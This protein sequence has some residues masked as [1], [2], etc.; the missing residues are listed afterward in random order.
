MNAYEFGLK[1]FNMRY[2]PLPNC[3][4][5]NDKT[6]IIDVENSSTGENYITP[7]Y[8]Y[9]EV[10][11]QTMQFV[12]YDY[13]LIRSRIPKRLN[14]DVVEDYLIPNGYIEPSYN[15]RIDGLPIEDTFTVYQYGQEYYIKVLINQNLEDEDPYEPNEF[16]DSFEIKAPRA[17]TPKFFGSSEVKLRE[18]V[19]NESISVVFFFS[20]DGALLE[21]IYAQLKKVEAN[22]IVF[23]LEKPLLHRALSVTRL[24]AGRNITPL[25]QIPCASINEVAKFFEAPFEDE[26]TVKRMFEE[27]FEERQ[28]EENRSWYHFDIAGFFIEIGADLLQTFLGKPLV[29][30]GETMIENL[31][32]DPKRWKYYHD[33]PTK[34][35]TDY[36]PFIP[37]I[38]WAVNSLGE[39]EQ[40]AESRDIGTDISTIKTDMK[41]AIDEIPVESYRKLLHEKLAFANEITD[42]LEELFKNIQSIFTWQNG[43]I[44]L[45][46]LLTGIYNSLIEAIAGILILVGNILSFPA[47]LV[48]VT[49]GSIMAGFRIGVEILENA[50]EAI[51][52][53]FSLTNI[54]EFF[55][56]LYEAAKTLVLNPA[57]PAEQ[58]SFLADAAKYIATHVDQIGYGIGY[59]IGFI[60]EEVITAILTGGAKTV[61]TA[62]KMTLDSFASVLSGVSKVTRKFLIDKPLDFI[63]AMSFLFK[64]M[65]NFDM[66]KLMAEFIEWIKKLFLTAK[67]FAI[68]QYNRLFN[69]A[70]KSVLKKFNLEPTSFEDGVLNMCP[71]NR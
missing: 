33:D 63:Y 12:T 66:K 3:V 14:A 9:K 40:E 62:L 15:N 1:Y 23:F 25:S 64:K 31:K 5:F 13:K 59:V 27:F 60:I 51:V 6:K 67:D 7:S 45:N 19:Q 47:K 4:V 46:A 58:I 65:K 44:Y 10:E 32:A 28:E 41:N 22:E 50:I 8:Y 18:L 17:K 36:E 34:N 52:S 29:Y 16:L 69:R 68:E 54:K 2:Q 30:L 24:K 26:N 48:E 39:E 21:T 71:I 37:G 11:E 56:G 38:K 49:G 43:L 42:K 35:G 55:S 53:F 70:E 20:D 57:G 61:A